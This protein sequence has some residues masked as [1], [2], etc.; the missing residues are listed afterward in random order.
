M[1]VWKSLI[2]IKARTPVS[3]SPVINRGNWKKKRISIRM[4]S[5]LNWHCTMQLKVVVLNKQSTFS[6]PFSFRGAFSMCRPRQTFTQIELKCQSAFYGIK[7]IFG[8]FCC[9]YSKWLTIY[10]IR[11][12]SIQSTAIR[13]KSQHAENNSVRRAY[14]NLNSSI[15][16][17]MLNH[18]WISR[19]MFSIHFRRFSTQQPRKYT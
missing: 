8:G 6:V 7:Y 13:L 11:I 4:N 19:F 10:Q 2:K 1:F 12:P 14:G 17:H 18:V 16:F 9:R 3:V 5:R 15:V